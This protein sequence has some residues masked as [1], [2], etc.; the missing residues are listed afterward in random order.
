MTE[1]EQI[2]QTYFKDVYLYLRRLSNNEN[3]A[4]EI[5]S[6]TFFKAMQS[7]SSFRGECDIRVWLCQIAKNCYFSYMK[8]QQRYTEMEDMDTVLE[9]ASSEDIEAWFEK[10]SDAMQIHSL[11]HKLPEPYKEVFMLRIFGELSFKQIA[12]IF[13]KTENWACVTFHRAK[14]KILEKMEENYE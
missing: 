7:L 11:L 10:E 14:Q 5:T 2:Y 3:L 6:E 13:Q 8:K 12:G 1:F 9:M 4:E